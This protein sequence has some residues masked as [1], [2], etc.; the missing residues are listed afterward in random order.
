ML[1]VVFLFIK[2]FVVVVFDDD[3]DD[4]DVVNSIMFQSRIFAWLESFEF[5]SFVVDV[6]VCV[7]SIK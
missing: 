1:F 4:D 7:E 3:D 5:I 6:V 2:P